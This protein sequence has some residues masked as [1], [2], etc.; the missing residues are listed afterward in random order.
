MKQYIVPKQS[1]SNAKASFLDLDIE[2]IKL[3]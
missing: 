3:N 2:V 1:T